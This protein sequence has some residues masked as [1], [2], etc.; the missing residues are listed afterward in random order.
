MRSRS[1]SARLLDA[2]HVGGEEVET[3]AVEVAACAVVV[4]SGAGIDVP[5]EARRRRGRW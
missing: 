2:C 1:R 4:L 5:R 3:V